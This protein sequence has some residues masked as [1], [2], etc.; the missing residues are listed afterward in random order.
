MEAPKF[1]SF[2]EAMHRAEL[3]EKEHGG[4]TDEVLAIRMWAKEKYPALFAEYLK[5]KTDK[6]VGPGEV[7]R[8]NFF[9]RQRMNDLRK[10]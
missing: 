3:L 2:S 9:G 10:R 1:S 8:S 4:I 5:N 6:A 7:I